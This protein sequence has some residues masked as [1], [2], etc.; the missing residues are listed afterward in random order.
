MPIF[1]NNFTYDK[2]S[3]LSKSNSTF[4]EQMYIKFINNDSDLPQSWKD[5]FKSLNEV[6]FL[7]TLLFKN[8]N[9]KSVNINKIIK[10]SNFIW[11]KRKQF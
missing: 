2:T 8:N 7:P 1:K 3:F 6:P 5:Y 4:I 11:Y 9:I 10:N